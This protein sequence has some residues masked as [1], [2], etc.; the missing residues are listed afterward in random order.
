MCVRVC[1]DMVN[2]Y[3]V[4]GGRGEEICMCEKQVCLEGTGEMAQVG[5]VQC[6]MK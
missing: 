3:C 4:R 1:E 6:G 5:R 2:R